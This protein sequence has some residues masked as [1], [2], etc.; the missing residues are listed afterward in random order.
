[1]RTLTKHL[2]AR[3]FRL[4]YRRTAR[5]RLAAMKQEQAERERAHAAWR[6]EACDPEAMRISARMVERA[7][8]RE[9]AVTV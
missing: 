2:R 1:M 7:R 6:R 5:R 9:M 8:G 4:R 3:L